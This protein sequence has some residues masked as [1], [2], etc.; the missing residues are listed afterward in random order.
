[1]RVTKRQLRRIIREAQWGN[2]T[3]GA[4]PLDE[5]PMDS[6]PMTP[7]MQQRV[8]DILVD[9]GSDPQELKASGDYPDL[10]LDEAEG[11]TKKYDDD[12]AL[13][14][15]QSTL[16]DS[17]QRG[18]IDKSVE[19]R[20]E[21]EEEE[22]EEKNES[23]RITR[24]QLRRI[25]KEAKVKII[26]EDYEDFESTPE[27]QD[28]LVDA[29]F[30]RDGT[31]DRPG[32]IGP[33][34]WQLYSPRDIAEAE[35]WIE[36]AQELN[37]AVNEAEHQLMSWR[38]EHD[39]SPDLPVSKEWDRAWDVMISNVFWDVIGPV[40]DK[41]ASQGAADTEP[42]NVALDELERRIDRLEVY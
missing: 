16:P 14:G 21:R 10:M 41:Y 33:T 3:G 11:S 30:K 7:E 15:K 27:V 28:M 12:S 2:F 4:A 9:S 34:D 25:I 20:E 31:G 38:E 26:A 1:M 29:D 8:F 39:L 19:D 23:V 37:M 42:R 13:R 5:P 40:M 18:I 17:L 32:E 36:A 35:R 24:H 22:G 6:G